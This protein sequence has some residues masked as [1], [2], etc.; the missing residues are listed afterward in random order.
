[1]TKDECQC[2]WASNLSDSSLDLSDEVK[3]PTM[4]GKARASAVRAWMMVVV[5]RGDRLVRRFLN[6]CDVSTYFCRW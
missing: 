6:E 3:I 2:L 5:G 1:M 4:G